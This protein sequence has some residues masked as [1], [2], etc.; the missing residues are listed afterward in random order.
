M[1]A[2]GAAVV[3]RGGARPSSF[4]RLNSTHSG[5]PSRTSKRASRSGGSL[6]AGPYE[7]SGAR[8]ERGSVFVQGHQVARPGPGRVAFGH[9]PS[10]TS[11][12]A[13]ISGKD[14]TV[15]AGS[16]RPCGPPPVG[17]NP[18]HV[19]R[20]AASFRRRCGYRTWRSRRKGY[21]DAVVT[22]EQTLSDVLALSERADHALK[23]FEAVHPEIATDKGRATSVN[24][25]HLPPGRRP[26]HADQSSRSA[27]RGKQ[28]PL[29][30]Q[31]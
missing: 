8:D 10:S 18:L 9:Y 14:E 28:A 17:W 20:D 5:T 19:M 7:M 1:G 27:S 23:Q 21:L 4:A 26:A 29:D 16:R 31:M 6:Q 15:P 25:R 24:V 13:V 22:A 12:T 30:R 2:D 11:P 3:A